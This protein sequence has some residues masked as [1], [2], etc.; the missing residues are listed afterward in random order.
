[1]HSKINIVI[2]LFLGVITFGEYLVAA[3]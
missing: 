1:M 3:E 2:Q